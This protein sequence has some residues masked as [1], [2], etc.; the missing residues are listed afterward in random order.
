MKR[1][2]G[3][4]KQKNSSAERWCGASIMNNIHDG[5]LK[6]M[7]TDPSSSDLQDSSFQADAISSVSNRDSEESVNKSE[8]EASVA[9]FSLSD[10]PTGDDK[11]GFEPYVQAIADFLTNVGTQP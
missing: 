10:K 3:F 9:P 1:S 2:N 4:V 11:L 6:S 5:S 8:Q 7:A